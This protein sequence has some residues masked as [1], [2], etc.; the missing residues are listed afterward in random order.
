MKALPSIAFGQFKG[1][2]GSVT[3]RVSKGR[4]IISAKSLHTH[5][6]S[7]AQ[8]TR[9]YKELT[10][11]Q[12]QGWAALAK[13]M[14]GSS[15]FGHTAELTPHNAFV[16]LNS[17]RKM[18][19]LPLLLDPPAYI[20]DIPSVLY[21]DIWITPTTIVFTGLEKPASNMVMVF[22]MSPS[23]SPGTTS[24]WSQTVIINPSVSPQWG[25]AD[26][27]KFYTSVMGYTP[28]QGKK[29]FCSFYWMDT[30]TGFVGEETLVSTLC[31]EESVVNNLI[32]VPRVRVTTDSVAKTYNSISGLD[33]E[34]TGNVP[35]ANVNVEL[36][37][38]NIAASSR[39]DL[40]EA[41][42]LPKFS[43]MYLLGRSKAADNYTPQLFLAWVE[44]RNGVSTCIIAHRAGVY[45]R[46]TTIDSTGFYK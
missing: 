35:V 25:E 24:G 42:Q 23:Q 45:F 14:K 3:A 9:K 4:Q 44:T 10:Q 21:D 1:S 11:S 38:D 8:A 28:A 18:A 12:M 16:R 43:A 32:Y 26:L 37:G 46:N 19:G 41:S 6:T 34:L 7:V 13:R 17:N 36:F 5:I 15:V 20:S 2:A 22:K 27:T 39:F 40:Q 33:M 29:Y 30:Q 31:Q